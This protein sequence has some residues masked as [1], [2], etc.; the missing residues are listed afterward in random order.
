[1]SH[2]PLAASL[3]EVVLHGGPAWLAARQRRMATGGAPSSAEPDRGYVEQPGE[4]PAAPSPQLTLPAPP[5]PTPDPVVNTEPR[6]EEMP[7]T[8][9]KK[10]RI[11]YEESFKR[12]VVREVLADGSAGSNARVARRRGLSDSIVSMWMKSYGDEVRRESKT[13]VSNG[14]PKSQVHPGDAA[15]VLVDALSK[16][17]KALVDERVD[18]AVQ[19]RMKR[20]L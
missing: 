20:L 13:L 16:Y 17:I 5:P 2:Q 19:E 14:A 12:E 7:A 3:G 4:R 18:Q 9:Q 15:A 8:N 11:R 6:E 1:M 10:K